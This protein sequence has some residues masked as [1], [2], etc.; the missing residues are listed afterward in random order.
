VIRKNGLID[1]RGAS[2]AAQRSLASLEG[3]VSLNHCRLFSDQEL[4]LL[5][6]IRSLV[7]VPLKEGLVYREGG[8]QICSAEGGIWRRQGQLEHTH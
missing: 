8:E 3:R 7:E 2:K 6:F 1:E 4:V 5:L